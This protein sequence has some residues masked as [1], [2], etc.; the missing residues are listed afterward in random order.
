[1]SVLSVRDLTVSEADGFAD[2][3][4]R[5]DKPAAGPV[6]VAWTTVDGTAFDRGGFDFDYLA[7]GGTLNFAPGETEKTV[8][9]SLRNTATVTSTDIEHNEWFFVKLS[10]PVGATLANDGTGRVTVVDNDT[11]V[12][13]PLVHVSDVIVD[14][15]AGAA[16][17]VVTL[18]HARGT[19]SSAP[20]SV[21]LRTRDGSAVSGSDY[22]AVQTTLTFAPGETAKTVVVPLNNDALAEATESFTLQLS[23]ARGAVIGRGEASASIVAND[24][25]PVVRP[26]ILIESAHWSEGSPWID[27]PV[28]LS[29]PSPQRITVRWQTVDDTAI[30]QTAG[31]AG[32]FLA[33]PGLLTFEPGQ[34]VQVVRLHTPVQSLPVEGAYPEREKRLAVALT[35]P[36]N[37][38]LA[39]EG[40]AWITVVDNDELATTPLLHVRDV[41]VDEAAGHALFAVTLGRVH[42]QGSLQTVQVEVSTADGSASAGSDYVAVT[43]T[44]TFLPGESVQTVAVPL[45]DDAAHERAETFHLRLSHPV[46]ATLGT[47]Q[48]TA[49]IGANDM[50]ATALPRIAAQPLTISEADRWADIVLTLS[51]P[52]T[53]QVAV[54][55]TL[56]AFNAYPRDDFF[57]AP[58]AVVFEP[59]ETTRVLRLDIGGVTASPDGVEPWER[60]Q[61]VL[62]SPVGA[63]LANGGV[64]WIDIVDNDTLVASP[65]VTA[66]DAWVDESAAQA[67]F[68]VTLGR[69]AGSSTHAP[70]TLQY[71]TRDG[72]ALAG[73]DYLPVQGSLT[74]LP[75][76]SAKVVAVPLVDDALIE[77]FETFEL[78]LTGSALDGSPIAL[79][80]GAAIASNDGTPKNLPS[81]S[82]VGALVTEEDAYVDLWVLLDAPGRQAVS[83]R[84]ELS[85]GTADARDFVRGSGTLVFDPGVVAQTVRLLIDPDAQIEGVET[86]NL[87]LSNPQGATLGVAQAQVGVFDADIGGVPVQSLGMGNDR[88]EVFAGSDRVVESILGGL[89]VVLAHADYTLPAQV[90]A[91]VLKAP[92]TTGT[93]NDESNH[94]VGHAGQ[95]RFDGR[96]GIDTV[97]YAGARAAYQVAGGQGSYTVSGGDA[98]QDVLLSIERLMFADQ[99]VVTDTAPGGRA[100]EVAALLNAGFDQVPAMA[101]VARWLA[102]FDT[103]ARDFGGRNEIAQRMLD[104]YVPGGIPHDAL[105]A[106]LWHSV[107][108]TPIAAADLG[109]FVA[110]L[111]SG[112]LTPASLL[113]LA[114]EQP[115]NTVEL[116]GLVG[117]P[118]TLDAQW[119]PTIEIG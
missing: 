91:L 41:V 56:K 17:F 106:H 69:A 50:A 36:T 26:R 61:L 47:S 78:V 115:L 19:A 48:A 5:L 116:G 1:M 15:G 24:A 4:I 94:F 93:G 96:G 113:V 38:T 76:E 71:T 39:H 33:E 66:R 63:T 95:N 12:P 79:S 53:A 111:D 99:L 87:V 90:E 77:G 7:A 9:I 67:Q 98:G 46:G 54:V 14:E 44:L 31:A 11:V 80:A 118:W 104:A 49:T 3:L 74:F 89:D 81:V 16:R 62:S 27:I 45:V 97:V 107:V 21:D 100:F 108:G 57:F 112:S 119:F 2:V 10:N 65:P 34:T 73:Q 30:R 64:S 110:L 75:G 92:A 109:N 20:V 37:A 29:A 32:H 83:V 25:T 59:G 82:A 103:L 58:G 52:S 68:V 70:I 6:S 18:G 105:V 43:R 13:L 8:R 101:E 55:T 102:E 84:W 28:V 85:P 22:T 35:E 51:A 72:S 23:N 42:G 117:V 114:A 86:I 40:V 88:Y 60:L